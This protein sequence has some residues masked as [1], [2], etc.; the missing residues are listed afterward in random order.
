MLSAKSIQLLEM[1]VNDFKQQVDKHVTHAMLVANNK[2][3]SLY[4]V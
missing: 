2:L 3:L 1:S 4:S